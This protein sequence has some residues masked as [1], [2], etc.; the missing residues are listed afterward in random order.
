ML[1][2]HSEAGFVVG[3]P[4][5]SPGLYDFATHGK[6]TKQAIHSSSCKRVGALKVCLPASS[7]VSLLV[8]K[9]LTCRGSRNP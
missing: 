5:S 6:L 4:F 3:T 2:A 8:T 1:D 7:A 9:F